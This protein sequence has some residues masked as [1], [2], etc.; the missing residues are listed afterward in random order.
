VILSE[1]L[2]VL[3][4]RW[5]IVV[6]GLCLTAGGV[7]GALQ[8]VPPAYSVTSELL[9]LPPNSVVPAGSNPY[10]VLGGLESIGSVASKTMTDDRTKRLVKSQF[11]E[12]DYGIGL[13]PTAAAPMLIVNVE[14][15][16]PQ[17]SVDAE[18]FLRE[19]LPSVLQQLQDSAAVP[20]KSRITSTVVIEPDRPKILRKSQIRMAVAA[21]AL[22]LLGTVMLAAL[23]DARAARRRRGHRAGGRELVAE[24]HPPTQPVSDD[25]AP[26]AERAPSLAGSDGTPPGPQPDGDQ[27]PTTRAKDLSRVSG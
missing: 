13:D 19:R 2:R 21:T 20:G 10:L 8:T 3:G 27:D 26:Q 14:S 4:R 6:L 16:D 11:G 7:V 23:L 18:R 5:Y 1:I 25:A 9:L 22:G 24:G 15:N 12:L 17:R